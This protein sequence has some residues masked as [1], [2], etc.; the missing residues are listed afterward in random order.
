[1]DY[2]SLWGGEEVHVWMGEEDLDGVGL[3]KEARH[4]IHQCQAGRERCL[5]VVAG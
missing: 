3:S 5:S 1:M 2:W 4:V